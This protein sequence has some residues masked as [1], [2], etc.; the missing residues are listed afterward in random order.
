[1]L[2][3]ILVST[4]L[5][6]MTLSLTFTAAA[7]TQSPNAH[8]IVAIVNDDIITSH[9]VQQRVLFML[10]TTG[11]KRDEA[12]VRRLQQTAMQN[13]VNERLQMQEAKSFDQEISAE[14]VERSMLRLLGGNGVEPEEI[15]Q[16]LAGLG[17]SLNTLRDQVRSEIAW[18]RVTGGLFG[19]R[20]RVSDSQIDETLSRILSKAEEPTYRVAE[21][22]IEATPEIG[23]MEGAIQGGHAMISQLNEG[24]PFQLLAQ[25]FS[26]APTAAKGGDLGFV[27]A[28]ELRAE[29]DE[30]ITQME[31]GKVHQQPILVPGGVYV[32]ALIQKQVSELDT[33]YRLKQVN[34]E[35]TGEQEMHD[36][37]D[38]LMEMK[39]EFNSCDTLEEK[40]DAMEMINYADMGELKA[41]E[42]AEAI[43]SKLEGTGINELS[44]PIETPNGPV[45]IMVCDR[46]T[47]GDN[48]PTRQQ[49]EDRLFDQELA[50]ASRRHLR[51]LRRRAAVVT[52]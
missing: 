13:L 48:I 3:N 2:K 19:S 51:D 52:R 34:I 42:A 27:H 10:A 20:I 37:M 26:S 33:L 14:E 9:D 32:V 4:A 31:A 5:G 44:D 47:T 12:S 43:T 36:A 21:I 30:V 50:Q 11:A 38:M 25:Q 7:Q 24:A 29:I 8:G 40:A 45:A 41:S 6:A 1:M 35:A 22:Y 23:G 28:G 15:A 39:A 46:Q 17:V 16:R 18:Q 49:T